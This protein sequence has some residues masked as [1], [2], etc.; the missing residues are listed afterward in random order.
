MQYNNDCEK[1]KQMF[2]KSLYDFDIH[3]KMIF[4]KMIYVYSSKPK[5]KPKVIKD[6]TVKKKKTLAPQPFTY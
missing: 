1:Y 5:L 6:F 3:F 4:L 2:L